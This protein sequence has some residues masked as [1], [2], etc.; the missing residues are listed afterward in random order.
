MK[1]ILRHLL[2]IAVVAL[3]ATHHALGADYSPRV[4][5]GKVTCGKK[6]IPGVPVTDGYNFALT[7]KNGSYELSLNEAASFVYITTPAGYLPEHNEYHPQFYKTLTDDCNQYDF[8]LIKNKKDDRKH[9]AYVQTDVQ[10][11]EERELGMY[12]AQVDDV[13]KELKQ[14]AKDYDIFGIDCGD[15]VSDHPELYPSTHKHYARLEL[16]VYRTMGNHDQNYDGRSDETSN[17]RFESIWGPSRYSFNRGNVHYIVIDNVFYI[18]RDYFYMGY[19]DEATYSWLEKDLA[20]VPENSTV[21]ISMHIPSHLKNPAPAFTYNGSEVSRQMVN[22]RGL[23]KLLEPYNAHIFSGHTHC[24][25]TLQFAPNLIEHNH[26]AACG[27]WWDLPVCQDGTP[28]GYAVYVVDGDDIKWYYKGA[29]TDRK[30]QFRAY[31]IGY[32]SKN[33]DKIVANVWNYDPEWKVEWLEDGVVKGDMT[34]FSGQDPFVLDLI[35]DRKHLRYSWIG[36]AVNDHMFSCTPE[37]PNAKITIRVTDRF[38]DVY[39]D[40]PAVPVNPFKQ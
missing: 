21:I 35:G 23:H 29:A 34:K 10:V 33:P 15:L 40:V 17:K 25:L 18:G 26:A 28:Q 16:P 37:N 13:K 9:V 2:T 19:I 3:F 32:D 14:Y 22:F 39:E 6:A 7:D 4:V 38:G 20:N 27:T 31:P 12:D 1:L 36:A 30:H 8:S 24:N 5:S 11:V